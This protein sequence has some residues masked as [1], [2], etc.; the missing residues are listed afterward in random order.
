MTG[1]DQCPCGSGQLYQE[2]CGSILASGA[3]LGVRAEALMRAR[4]SAYVRKNKPFLLD[5]W[6]PETRPADL[7]FDDDLE[8][9]GLEII[10]IEAG[11]GV[12]I[13]G[14]V[15]FKARFHRGGQNFELHERSSFTRV[16]GHWKYVTGT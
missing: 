6:H 3:G 16:A 7:T 9:L 15:E 4:Y 5:S 10:D 13:N 1:E 11:S 12:D 2:H 14:I 8:W